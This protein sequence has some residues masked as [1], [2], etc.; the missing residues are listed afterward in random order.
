MYGLARL[1]WSKRGLLLALPAALVAVPSCAR[2]DAV[3]TLC[4]AADESGSGLNL[5]NA[6]LS[7]PDPSTHINTVTFFCN[8]PATI[9][10]TNP[11][12]IFQAT[13]ID[14]GN[15]ITLVGNNTKSLIVVANPGNS[16]SL[17]NLTLRHPTATPVHCINWLRF[18][19]E[20]RVVAANGDTE[21]NN[22]TIDSSANAV[23]L[24]SGTL[25]IVSSQFTGNSEAV[26]TAAPGVSTVT[27]TGSV[28]QNNS[29][30]P[31]Q[32][33][34]TI[35]ITDTRFVNNDTAFLVGCGQVTID[36]S[37]F[38]AHSGA[39]GA[40]A[41][42]CA[43][44]T[45]SHTVFQNNRSQDPGGAITSTAP[46]NTVSI[47]L[48]ADQFLNN[49]SGD[50]GGAVFWLPPPGNV[51][52]TLT[53]L[54]SFFTGNKAAS[55]GAIDIDNA[56]DLSGKTSMNI[57][58]TAFSGNTATDAGGAVN[59]ASTELQILRGVFAD[60]TAGRN[61]GALFINNSSELHSIV[62]NSLLVRNGAA[63]GSAFYGADT[64]FINSTIDSNKGLAIANI[65]SHTPVHIQ[66]TNSIVS[67][68]PQGGC[69][70]AG[71]FDDLGN[72]LQFN[73]TRTDC[74]VSISVADPRLDFMYIPLPLSP[75]RGNGNLSVCMSPPVSG[76]DVYGL[77]RPSG[78]A[79][80]I[81]AVEGDISILVNGPAAGST[82]L[83]QLLRSVP[84][85][86]V[87][88]PPH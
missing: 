25:N 58:A 75:P 69:G 28:F 23:A 5:L 82:L 37:S 33:T 30:P 64:D 54:F 66:F 16:L 47:T 3:V 61:G 53:I 85:G 86:R 48:R 72:N 41:I 83:Q 71:L 36:R 67:N 29:G 12:E 14:G 24:T 18:G 73:G 76:T 35:N 87:T 42:G 52:R 38:Q 79:C 11:L 49:T 31:I 59:A 2:A 4:D 65:A 78:G 7:Q 81:G 43:S 26:I 63:S 21:L 88:Q 1:V 45:I 80:T 62:A 9:Q 39:V 46:F 84:F 19:C 22:V 60:N 44:A 57:G 50:R 40:L 70:P 51:N 17:Y 6:L 68:N 20:G 32:A 27:I 74:G 13:K 10:V 34:G 77:G 55:G 8:G 56:V 15:M